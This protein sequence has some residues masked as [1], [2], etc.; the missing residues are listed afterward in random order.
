MFRLKQ[1]R[2]CMK[3]IL[4]FALIIL[5]INSSFCVDYSKIDSQSKTVPAN[6][7]TAEEIAKYLTRNLTSP[8][9]KARA[10]YIWI[11]QNIKYDLAQ[12]NTNATYFNSQELVDDVLKNRKG[13]CA[14]YAQLF[15]SCCQ[16]AGLQSYV[17]NGYTKEDGKMAT[18]SHAWNAVKIENKFYCIDVTWAAGYLD[19]GKYVHVFRDE[20][21]MIKPAEFI[22]THIP[23]DPIW[24][25]SNNPITHDDFSKSDFSKLK[26]TS[27]FNFNDSIALLDN[28]SPLD[29]SIRENLRIFH[30]GITNPL[31]EAQFTYNQKSIENYKYNKLVEKF[32]V[33][34]DLF[35][36]SV[37]DFNFYILSKNKQFDN[38]S[39]KD[40]N[41]KEMLTTSRQKMES[42]ENILKSIYSNNSEMNNFIN[43]MKIAI[44]NLKSNL[45][46]E[47]AFVQ[48]YIKTWT[49]LRKH[50][51]VTI[52]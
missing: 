7:K 29:K 4:L 51:F 34:Q 44:E 43:E 25:F 6:L 27:N 26:I 22:K 50:L 9:D 5:N 46:N 52:R 33:S 11:T 12:L 24:Q 3:K 37:E 35:N 2:L 31:I 30:F 41:I 19:A 1:N 20:Y 15:Y 16:S 13:V 47:D 10:I 38:M 18:I 32:K 14:N 17:I 23:F 36:K 40:E 39:L 21:F 42:A 48:K 45:D 49:P 8:T 28:L